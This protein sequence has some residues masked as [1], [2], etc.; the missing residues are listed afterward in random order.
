MAPA[1]AE[2]FIEQYQHVFFACHQRH[3]RDVPRGTLVSE[4][5]LHILGHLDLT[6]ATRV[7]ELAEHMGLSHSSISITLD[8]LQRDGYVVR[9]TN[10]ADRRVTLVRLTDSGER[11]RDAQ[12]VL[13]PH[14]VA[15]LFKRL[16]PAERRTARDGMALLSRAAAHLVS[17]R[18]STRASG[19]A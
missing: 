15:E 12:R 19:A 2:T 11:V 18:R 8:R 14:L 17:A 3:V 6:R 16:S 9:E 5:Q 7:G 1:F 4:Q 10:H 13:E